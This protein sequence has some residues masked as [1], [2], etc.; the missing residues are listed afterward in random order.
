MLGAVSQFFISSLFVLML[1]YQLNKNLESMVT[2]DSLTGILNRRGLEDASLKMQGLCRRVHMGMAVLL[3]DIDYF[4]TVNDVHGHLVGDEVLRHMAKIATDV[5]RTGD[6][7]GRYGGEEFIVFM[8]NTNE[9]EAVILAE[10]VRSAIE[11]RPYLN[12]KL[13]VPITVSIGVTDSVRAGYDFKG[14]VATADSTLYAAKNSG[15]NKVMRFTEIK[16]AP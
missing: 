13:S 16:R 1:S 10:R 14:L 2:V 6:V 5:L 9:S 15:R 7:L 11:N 8:P 12:G 4:K 3:I